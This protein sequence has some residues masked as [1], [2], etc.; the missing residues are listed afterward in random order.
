MAQIAPT[1]QPGMIARI[2]GAKVVD[3]SRELFDLASIIHAALTEI[4]GTSMRWKI[5]GFP[6]DASTNEPIQSSR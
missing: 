4:G 2:F 6:D 3:R 1:N 5:D